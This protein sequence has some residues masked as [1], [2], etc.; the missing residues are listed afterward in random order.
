MV[1]FLWRANGKPAAS[2]TSTL[3][4]SFPT[5]FYTNAV[6]WADT[7]GLLKDTGTA[8]NPGSQSP[9]ANIVTY[10]YRELAE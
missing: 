3:A 5:D 1:T 4:G 8:F 7:N 10:L 9:R 6:A 2:G